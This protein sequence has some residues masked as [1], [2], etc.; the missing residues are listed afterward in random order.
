MAKLSRR[1]KKYIEHYPICNRYQ[2]LRHQ[3]YGKQVLI[4]AIDRLFHTVTLNFILALPESLKDFNVFFTITD[5]YS[6]RVALISGKNTWKAK[7][8][9]KT[10]F[11]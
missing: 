4:P 10:L 7:D 1:I 3:P 5:K 6:K 11:D 2:T 8:W 9:A